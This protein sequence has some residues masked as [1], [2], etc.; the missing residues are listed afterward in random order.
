MH[1]EKPNF[2]TYACV[3]MHQTNIQ[4]YATNTETTKGPEGMDKHASRYKQISNSKSYASAREQ[5]CMHVCMYICIEACTY[6][7]A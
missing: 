7:C 3:F 4:A 1:M 2:E 5:V 6:V